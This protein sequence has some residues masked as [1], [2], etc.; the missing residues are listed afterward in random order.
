MAI[1]ISVLAID[2][3]EVL[4]F[5]F[6]NQIVGKDEIKK[7]NEEGRFYCWFLDDLKNSNSY[8]NFTDYEKDL[9]AFQYKWCIDQPRPSDGGVYLSNP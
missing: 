4:G 7:H 3:S 9:I 2:K 1:I 8:E 6:L 5:S